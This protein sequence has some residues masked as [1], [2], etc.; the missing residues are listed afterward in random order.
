M[1]PPANPQGD[2]VW[3]LIVAAIYFG[4]SIAVGF[5]AKVA[6][7]WL[8]QRRGAD[9]DDVHAQAGPNRNKPRRVF[10]LGIWRTED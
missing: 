6:L 2:P 1:L 8:M 7:D 9:L 3:A 4:S 10:L 5:A